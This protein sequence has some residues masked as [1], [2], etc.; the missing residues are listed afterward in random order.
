M[1]RRDWRD[2]RPDRAPIISLCGNSPRPPWLGQVAIGNVPDSGNRR[3]PRA[4][5]AWYAMHSELR[6]PHRPR[7][8]TPRRAYARR[9]GLADTNDTAPRS[10]VGPCP[11][12]LVRNGS[13]H[14]CPV[15]QSAVEMISWADYGATHTR[16]PRH[17]SAARVHPATP[18]SRRRQSAARRQVIRVFHPQRTESRLLSCSECR[19]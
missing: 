1:R 3:R 12:G 17:S 6:Y 19:S 11:D 9:R 5:A 2:R 13:G 16:G 4:P 15:R 14:G 8:R 7:I 10:P 18:L